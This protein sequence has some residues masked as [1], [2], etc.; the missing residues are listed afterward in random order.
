ML[1]LQHLCS[2]QVHL[3]NTFCA[4]CDDEDLFPKF[5]SRLQPPPACWRLGKENQTPSQSGCLQNSCASDQQTQHVPTT[6][7]F[8][9]KA[10]P[11]DLSLAICVACQCIPPNA[12]DYLGNMFPAFGRIRRVIPMSSETA[13]VVF[14]TLS[15]ARSA[16]VGPL[17]PGFKTMLVAL[18]TPQQK[19][20]GAL[21]PSDQS[22]L[23]T[24]RPKYTSLGWAE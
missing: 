7:N 18:Y 13:I 10:T 8:A 23:S 12:M 3:S 17:P 22:V 4:I 24:S 16:Q 9:S 21:V 11:F 15:E 5:C 19:R 6:P 14:F 1:P 20:P 2:L